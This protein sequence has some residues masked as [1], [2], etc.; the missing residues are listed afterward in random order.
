ME[1]KR[2]EKEDGREAGKE[3]NKGKES[4]EDGT[5]KKQSLRSSAIMI[6]SSRTTFNPLPPFILHPFYEK[7]GFNLGLHV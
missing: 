3:E 4:Y 1:R 6:M 7:E 2:K 5:M